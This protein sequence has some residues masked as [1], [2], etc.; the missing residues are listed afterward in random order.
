MRKINAFIESLL[1]YE[2]HTRDLIE[3]IVIGLCFGYFVLQFLRV[4]F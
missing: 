2:N 4:S 3:I 1:Q